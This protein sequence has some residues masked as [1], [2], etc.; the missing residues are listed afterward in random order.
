MEPS[1]NI[2]DFICRTNFTLYIFNSR[3]M[4]IVNSIRSL[5]YEN[6]FCQKLFECVFA[7]KT[8]Q[9]AELLFLSKK[10]FFLF[11]F[12]LKNFVLIFL[13][14]YVFG[15]VCNRHDH[16]HISFPFFPFNFLTLA[17]SIHIHRTAFLF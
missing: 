17:K 11:C 6:L 2:F 7:S 10:K 9:I 1:T 16:Q 8:Q 4:R 13:F 5:N 12:T 15:Y 3:I 14:V